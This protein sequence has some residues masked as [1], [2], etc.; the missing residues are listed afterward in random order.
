MAKRSK[1]DWSKRVWVV[2]A[3]FRDGTWDICDFIFETQEDNHTTPYLPFASTNFYKAQKLKRQAIAHCVETS[4]YW[5]VE[6]FRVREYTRILNGKEKEK[7]LLNSKYAHKR[8]IRL[9]RENL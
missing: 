5:K 9:A 3:R 8:M 1:K 2:E 6:D 4:S 7:K